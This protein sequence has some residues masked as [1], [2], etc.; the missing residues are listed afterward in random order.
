MASNQ[1][2]VDVSPQHKG[3]VRITLPV[4]ESQFL[5]LLL[6]NLTSLNLSFITCEMGITISDEMY[7]NSPQL[8]D[9]VIAQ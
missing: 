6:H 1:M 7:S 4:F 5:Y 8:S 2:N 3:E 9:T